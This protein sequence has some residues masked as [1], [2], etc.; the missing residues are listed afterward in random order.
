MRS[1]TSV[2]L[3]HIEQSETVYHFL[4]PDPTTCTE[5]RITCSSIDAVLFEHEVLNLISRSLSPSTL[6]ELI[7][8]TG[9]NYAAMRALSLAGEAYPPDFDGDT[10]V[11]SKRP[12]KHIA[13]TLSHPP[14]HFYF[15][16]SPIGYYVSLC[17]YVVQQ[18]EI[19]REDCAALDSDSAVRKQREQRI[20]SL[21]K[22]LVVSL[23]LSLSLSLSMYL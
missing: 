22:V 17:R 19:A 4:F 3:S 13:A 15:F 14:H 23:S 9:S 16:T 7:C 20:Q 6:A 5:Y 2:L 21:A 12:G 1:S 10:S 11:P 8:V 18:V